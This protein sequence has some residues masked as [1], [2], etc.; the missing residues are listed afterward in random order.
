MTQVV[1][2]YKDYYAS[3][4]NSWSR[5]RIFDSSSNNYRI[6]KKRVRFDRWAR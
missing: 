6:P 4:S 3:N 1:K 2:G 5:S